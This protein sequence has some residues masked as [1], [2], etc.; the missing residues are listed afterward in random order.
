MRGQDG[1][2]P[3][4]SDWRKRCGHELMEYFHGQVGLIAKANALRGMV[5]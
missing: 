5:K 4:S 2:M 1:Q 3:T